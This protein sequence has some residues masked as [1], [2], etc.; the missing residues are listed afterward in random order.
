M[1]KIK[2][3]KFLFAGLFIIITAGSCKKYLEGINTDPTKP[4][5]IT[6]T[7]SLP[8]SEL[9]LAYT[10]GGDMSRFSSIFMQYVTGMA[11]QMQ[12]YSNYSFTEDDVNNLWVNLYTGPMVNLHSQIAINE[13]N[14]NKYFAGVSRVLLAYSLGIATDAWG[15]VPFSDA[16]QGAKQ[17]QPKYDSQQAVYGSIQKLLSEAVADL[18]SSGGLF[19][20]GQKM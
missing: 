3:I 16:F 4:N 12:S 13:K 19:N 2:S 20:R 17:L 5:T 1:K 9:T 10:V 14:G 6:P 18:N 15:D 11:R 7:V 8:Y